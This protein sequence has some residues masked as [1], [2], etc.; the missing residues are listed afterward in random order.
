MRSMVEGAAPSV[1]SRHLPRVAGED[2][3]RHHPLAIGNC[4]GAMAALSG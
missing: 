1:A 4:A 2:Q 3:L